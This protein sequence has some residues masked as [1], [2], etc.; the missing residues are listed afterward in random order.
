MKT[1]RIVIAGGGFAGLSAAMYLDKTLARRAE[2]EVTLISRENFILFT[3]MLHEVAAGDL[4]PGDI[5]NPLRRILLHVK[6]VEADVQAIDLN[7]RRVHCA[8]G[9]EDRELEF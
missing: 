5:V 2:A 6:V 4:Y 1:T 3:P 8:G 7:L 9:V